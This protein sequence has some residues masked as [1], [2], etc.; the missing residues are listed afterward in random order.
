MTDEFLEACSSV[1]VSERERK[2]SL[3]GPEFR[4][5]VTQV[6]VL[7]DEHP[8]RATLLGGTIVLAAVFATEAFAAW[9]GRRPAVMAAR[10][11]RRS[12]GSVR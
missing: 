11:A 4:M 9:H 7:M 10:A 6:W 2:S 12:A 8:G 3:P 1:S 5:P